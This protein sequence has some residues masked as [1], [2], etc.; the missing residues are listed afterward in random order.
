MEERGERRRRNDDEGGRGT[1]LRKKK[2]GEED[3]CMNR[4]GQRKQK[5]CL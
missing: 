1:E 2:W 4:G 5:L 3:K